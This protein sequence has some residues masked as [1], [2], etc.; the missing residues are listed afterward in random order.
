MSYPANQGEALVQRMTSIPHSLELEKQSNTH[1]FDRSSRLIVFLALSLL[2]ITLAQ[3]AYR[4]TLPTDGFSSY[5]ADVTNAPIFQKNL[6]GLPSPLQA[7]DEFVA[8]GGLPYTL[9]VQSPFLARQKL[10]AGDTVQYTVLRGGKEI[11]L[12]VPLYSWTWQGIGRAFL[13]RVRQGFPTN[14]ASW[15]ALVLVGFVF[16]QRPRNITAQLM[17]LFYTVELTIF[18][19]RIGSSVSVADL[20]NPLAYG[21]SLILGHVSYSIFE[22]P[23]ILHLCLTFPRPKSFLEGRPWLVVILYV[24]PWLLFFLDLVLGIGVFSFISAGV[25]ALLC[26]LTLT[27]TFVTVKDPVNAARVRWFAFGFALS[28]L[29]GVLY[30]LNNFSLIPREV[31]S[32]VSVFP[33]GLV[34]TICLAIAILGYRLFDI[35]IIIN[36]TLVYG[37]LSAC[38]IGLYIL[39]VGALGVLFRAQGN[40]ILSLLATGFVAVL[41]QPL[42]ERL[43]SFVNHLMYGEREEPYKLFSKLNQRIESAVEPEKVLP[44]ILETI[45][46][47][48]KLPFASIALYRDDKSE[49]V[50]QH[51][52]SSSIPVVFPLLHQGE[53]FGELCLEPRA[54]NEDFT[55]DE[56]ELLKTMSQQ[57]SVA[58]YAVRQTL[59]LQRSRERLITLRE[60]ERLR[61]RRDLHDGLGPTL[62]GLNLQ[63]GLLQTLIRKDPEGAAGVVN[64]FRGELKNA[65]AE[66]RQIVHDLRPGS[67][68]E[69]GLK[70]ALEQLTESLRV[71]TNV[72]PQIYLDSQSLPKLSAALEVAIYRI[73]QEALTNAL[74]HAGAKTIT[75]MI[76]LRSHLT[77]SIRDDG[78]GLP[79]HYRFGLGLRS[80]RERAEELGGHLTITTKEKQ[81]TEI[82]AVFP[83]G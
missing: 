13:D 80:M 59:D 22:A 34:L 30:I 6:L 20:L 70:G 51:G 54:S 66:I 82:K 4:F 83:L 25:Y 3:K 81:G 72:T 27:H 21:F 56:L 77:L 45:T 18:I 11:T 61:I 53:T 40:L 60:E 79:E 43:Q 44:T 47:A 9:L 49:I 68:D 19:S 28:S 57:V 8:V 12:E 58:A 35:D 41:F 42:R 36:R 73:T 32:F 62:A 78:G 15:L 64:E 52:R 5:P 31:Y 2:F 69:L 1:R 23:L 37:A 14:Y 17:L 74:K 67:L 24:L 65:I 48:L 71:E 63:A 29:F 46:Q 55:S 76:R 75:V 38:V 26:A 7:G 33:S 39:V 16:W 10:E 50:S